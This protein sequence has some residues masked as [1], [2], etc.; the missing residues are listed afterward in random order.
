MECGHVGIDGFDKITG[1]LESQG[2]CRVLHRR[3]VPRANLRCPTNYIVVL[4]R[5]SASAMLDQIQRTRVVDREDGPPFK[6]LNGLALVLRYLRG[7]RHFCSLPSYSVRVR[8]R[9]FRICDARQNTLHVLV[10]VRASRCGAYLLRGPMRSPVCQQVRVN[11]PGR[12]AEENE[13]P[14]L[15][16]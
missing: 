11:K 1:L 12:R 3:T 15:R 14:T 9:D 13:N 10:F 8:P 5:D 6:Y 7:A 4:L 16:L 2:N